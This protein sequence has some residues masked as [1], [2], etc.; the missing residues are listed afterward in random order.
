LRILKWLYNHIDHPLS[1]MVASHTKVCHGQLRFKLKPAVV[2][3]R[4]SG[5]ISL[6]KIL[7]ITEAIFSVFSLYVTVLNLTVWHLYTQNRK[8][9]I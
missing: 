6:T 5:A 7:C 9:C 4:K 3:L 2:V 8:E 1:H